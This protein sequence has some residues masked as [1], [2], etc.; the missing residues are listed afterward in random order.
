MLNPF[1]DLLSYS[2]LAPL[3][4]RLV[5]GIIFIDLGLL[6]FRSEKERWLD[7]F[8]ALQLRP[9]DFFVYLYGFLQVAGG[10]LLLIGL[11]TQ[12]AALAFVIFTGIELY[13]E[14]SAREVLKR[15]IVFYLLIFAIS[16]SLL[17]TGAGAYAFDIPL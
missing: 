6:K 13:I 5:I 8:E 7:S 3:I 15:D 11:W 2:L 16:L 17:F 12:V 1:P 4:L 10:I 14:W 9:A